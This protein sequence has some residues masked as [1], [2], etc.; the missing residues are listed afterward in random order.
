MHR[1]TSRWMN[2]ELLNEAWVKKW[3]DT[4]QTQRVNERTDECVEIQEWIH[5]YTDSDV[6]QCGGGG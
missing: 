6:E 5:R 1:L 2:T 4:K 3:I